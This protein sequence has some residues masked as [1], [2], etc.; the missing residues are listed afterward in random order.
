MKIDNATKKH[1]PIVFSGAAVV[2]LPCPA[3]NVLT[4][5]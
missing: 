4:G 3:G 2:D 1:G 5:A